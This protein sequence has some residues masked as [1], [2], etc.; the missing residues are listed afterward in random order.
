MNR[1]YRPKLPRYSIQ[2]GFGIPAYL[3][4]AKR[5][6]LS[7]A[8]LDRDLGDAAMAIGVKVVGTERR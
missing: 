1:R 2:F 7:L 3:E 4:L 5:R 8:T 6:G